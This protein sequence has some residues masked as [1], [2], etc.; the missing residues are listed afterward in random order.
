M[1]PA[2]PAGQ[3]EM[4]RSVNKVLALAVREGLDDVAEVSAHCNQS[5][6]APAGAECDTRPFCLPHHPMIEAVILRFQ[7]GSLRVAPWSIVGFCIVWSKEVLIF[8][9]VQDQFSP[10]SHYPELSFDGMLFSL[11][12]L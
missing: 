12:A 10:L 4:F 9:Q 5:S 2:A 3:L 6:N 1:D 11:G 7:S 8:L